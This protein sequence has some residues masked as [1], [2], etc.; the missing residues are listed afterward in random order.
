MDGVCPDR[1]KKQR[2]VI[3]LVQIRSIR[4]KDLVTLVLHLKSLTHK[5][6]D[7]RPSKDFH[8]QWEKG[9]GS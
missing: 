4:F 6:R 9:Q 5:E 3:L 2:F 8:D 1:K 7:V